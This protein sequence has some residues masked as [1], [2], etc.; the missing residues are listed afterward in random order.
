[1]L[2]TES[3]LCAGLVSLDHVRANYL[4]TREGARDLARP[5]RVGDAQRR[6]EYGVGLDR[7]PQLGQADRLVTT[8]AVRRPADDAKGE[9]RR[10][11]GVY[12]WQCRE[13]RPVN[14]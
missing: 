5:R 7:T 12:W 13:H 6:R 11:T 3:G 4:T 2:F 8:A 14:I 1:M 10:E 9:Q